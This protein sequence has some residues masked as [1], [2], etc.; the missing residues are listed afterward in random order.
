[1]LTGILG[2]LAGREYAGGAS[3]GATDSG[4]AP[5]VLITE[6]SRDEPSAVVLVL[7][8]GRAQSTA[9]AAGWQL[10]HARMVPIA[11]VARTAAPGAAV[12]RLR[13]RLRGWNGPRL[14]PVLDTRW[15]LA[16]ARRH[17]PGARVI[18]VGHSMGGRAALRCAGDPDVA[19][20][21][22]LAPWIEPGEP[23]EHLAGVPLV[24]AHGD[25]DRITDPRQ[26][27][28]FAERAEAVGAHV[29]WHLI[30]GAGH[31]M[32]RHADQWNAVIR[33]FV[34]ARAGALT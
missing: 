29:R 20:V 23:V 27:H 33:D 15:A 28:Q 14:D 31:A 22:A 21:C 2:R 7:P 26:S 12:W 19:G 1:M 30:P 5:R 17:H 10:A 18:L 3:M 11:W 4:V 24:I 8:G 9:P 34:G 6:A 25:R 13:Y 16:Q 32:V